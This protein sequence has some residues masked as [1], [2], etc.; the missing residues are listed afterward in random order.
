MN[1]YKLKSQILSEYK[2]KIELHA[3]TFPASGCSEISPK[4]LVETYKKLDYDAVTVTNH[5]VWDKNACKEE[6]IDRFLN[7]FYETQKHGNDLGLKVYLGAEVRF[8]ENGNDYLVFGVDKKM[9]EEIYDFLPYG[10]ENLRKNCDMKSSVFIQAHP[11][12]NGMEMIDTDL[13]DGIEVYN[14]HPNH[15][16]RVGLAALYAKKENISIITAGSD[17]H[18]ANQNHEGLAALRVSQLPNDSFELAN[19]IKEQN[20]FLEIGRR[21]ILFP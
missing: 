21:T 9:L 16:S 1:M 20:Y 4:V 8:T 7:D 17:F 10:V 15:N 19:L 11:M 13:L 3:H 18:H 2:Y 6:Y 14:M 5:F 12:R